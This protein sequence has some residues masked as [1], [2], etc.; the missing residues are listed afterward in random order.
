M[1][2]KQGLPIK[3]REN[4]T[5]VARELFV[6]MIDDAEQRGIA[7]YGTTLQTHNGRDVF[8]DQL[9]EIVDQWQYAVQSK[10]ENADLR[11]QLAELQKQLTEAEEK[12]RT[13]AKGERIKVDTKE[14]RAKWALKF[15]KKAAKARHDIY[16]LCDELDAIR[17]TLAATEVQLAE[18][19]EV[20]VDVM[21]QSCQA[22]E[23]FDTM[24][25]S[26]YEGAAE[27]LVAV[28]I[29]EDCN[30]EPQVGAYGGVMRFY[31]MHQE[32]TG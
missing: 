27:Y 31:K 30:G 12:A 8:Q 13:Y 7:T 9:E 32:G 29:F 10:M 1:S 2:T 14:M 4:V 16:D 24:C 26:A 15:G 19:H 18:A 6:K 25:L 21:N 5:P 3:G 23:V 11:K 22:G 28:G 20:L 17:A